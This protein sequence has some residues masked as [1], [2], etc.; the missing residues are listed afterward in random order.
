MKGSPYSLSIGFSL[1]AKTQ[2]VLGAD[3][4][5]CDHLRAP[6]KPAGAAAAAYEVGTDGGDGRLAAARRG[7]GRSRQR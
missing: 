2:R 7:N 3:A 4:P 6:D 5:I 1:I